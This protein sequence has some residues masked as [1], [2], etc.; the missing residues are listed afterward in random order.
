[1]LERSA[2]RRPQRASAPT[3]R[4]TGAWWSR[5]SGHADALFEEVLAPPRHLPRHPL[6]LARFARAGL[7]SASGL[8]RS[9]FEGERARALLA[10][11][12]A[13]SM[14]PLR[15]AGHGRVRPRARGVGAHAVGWPVT[16]GGSQ[17]LADALAAHLRACGGTV[18]TGRMVDLARRARFGRAG[19]A[20]R[21][22]AAA[23]TPSPAD[24]VARPLT[25]PARASSSSTG[26]STARSRGARR[27]PG[28][29]ARC[30]W[31]ARSR[32]STAVRAR[33]PPRAAL[34]AARAAHAVRPVTR[35]AGQAHRL[36]LLPRAERVD[37]RHDR[38]DRGPGRALR[39]RLSATGSP[40]AR[41]MNSAEVERRN[42]NYIGGDINGGRYDLHALAFPV[43]RTPRRFPASS[44]AR[45]RRPRA[46]A[47]TACA[48]T[49][50]PGRRSGR[51]DD[52][53]GTG[54]LIST[55]WL[56]H[57]TCSPTSSACGARSTSCSATSS[58]AR[59]GCAAAASRRRSTSSTSTTRRARWSRPT[60]PG[61]TSRDVALEIRGRQ[62]LIAGERRPAQAAGRLYQQIEIEH[63]PFRRLVE[64][65]RRGGGRRGARLLR[66][67]HPRGRDPARPAG[68]DGA[69]RAH[70]R[71]ALVS[72][73]GGA[74]GP[75][76][77]RR[78]RSCRCATRRLPGH[79]DAAGGR[80]GALDQAGQRRA[81]AATGCW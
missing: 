27:R 6:L 52:P 19:P 45:R 14:L 76:C 46:A 32:R 50:P 33:R 25:G 12:A 69:P 56:P 68:R 30:T 18:E 7:R 53:G 54:W 20:R 28:A 31:A 36:G 44:C 57:A 64:L 5:S 23:A 16:R 3:A 77:P 48:A 81:R 74:A 59:P 22:P 8:A 79:A 42:P 43:R 39:A 66:G 9:R 65:G 78:C 11:C 1:M 35:T 37:P 67:R 62:L 80:A 63:G 4:P 38:R 73:E 51:L 55:R 61:W 40:R 13:H 41:A 21:H 34:R 58:S 26:R 24:R 75:A 47:C 70:R 72:V 10:G 60:S 15:S 17:R 71:A 2:G 49:G 29:P